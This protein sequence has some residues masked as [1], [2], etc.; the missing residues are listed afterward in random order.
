MQKFRGKLKWVLMGLF[1]PELVVYTAWAQ[2]SEAKD[3]TKKLNNML[4]SKVHYG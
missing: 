3:M 2:W 4:N 1:A